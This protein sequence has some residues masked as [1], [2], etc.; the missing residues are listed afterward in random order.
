MF[1]VCIKL[2]GFLLGGANFTFLCPSACGCEPLV[3]LFGCNCMGFRH[4]SL[5]LLF[6]LA[7]LPW[8]LQAGAIFF[9]IML[10][11]LW[12]IGLAVIVFS[13]FCCLV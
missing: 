11:S 10:V 1:V 5:F 13:Y 12:L 2:P 8:F 7:G 9:F 3:N 4:W 6:G